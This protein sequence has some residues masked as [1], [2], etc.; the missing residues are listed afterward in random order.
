MSTPTTYSAKTPLI[1]GILATLVLVGGFG[2]W[3]AMTNIS[4]AIIASGQIEVDKNR[5]IVQHPDGGVVAEILVDEGDPVIAGQTLIQLDP[6]LLQSEQTII[7]DQL[8]ELRARRGRL[9]A[10]RD[11]V[12][13]ISFDPDLIERSKTDA[14]VA[15]LMNGQ[16]RLFTARLE[17]MQAQI[18][19]LGKR[20]GQINNQIEG[21]DAQL[22][23]LDEQIALIK[24]ELEGQQSLLERGLAQAARVLALQRTE[25]QLSGQVGD[26]TARRAESEGRITEIDIEINSLMIQ[27]REAAISQLRDQQFRELELEERFRALAE[28]LD[29][30]TITAPVSGV[31]YGLSIYTPRS[32]IRAAEPVMYLIP[33]DRPL[34]I[35]AQVEP[36]HIDKLFIG[37]DV[38]MRFSAFDQRTTPELFGKVTQISADA[39]TDE[40]TRMSYYRAEIVLNEEE[41]LKLPE[42][43][44]LIPGMPVE[45]FIRTADRTPLDY[46]LKPL[47]DYFTKAFRES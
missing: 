38:M 11:N 40:A 44:Q 3:A 15:D 32:V 47:T 30:M 28:R 5:Q 37:Q 13:A 6:T 31:I 36:I 16:D 26:L 19:A 7:E 18:E 8:F 34:V 1:I 24:E 42:G 21:I 39:F 20:R 23:A 25:A 45:S 14:D 43:V 35:A 27:R 17:T 22:V 46:L 33:Q 2:S 12:D 9:V 4:G 29:R 41:L 10:E